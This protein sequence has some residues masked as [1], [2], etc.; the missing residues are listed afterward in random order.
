MSTLEFDVYPVQLVRVNFPKTHIELDRGATQAPPYRFPELS[1]E[2]NTKLTPDELEAFVLLEIKSEQYSNGDV[3]PGSFEEGESP[4]V[5]V[6]LTV[7]AAFQCIDEGLDEQFRKELLLRFVRGENPATVVWAY[8]RAHLA[9]VVSQTGLP[10]FHIP[11]VSAPIRRIDVSTRSPNEGD[12]KDFEIGT[13][14]NL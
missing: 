13:D 1:V 9:Y 4:A 10:T 6:D 14:E 11:L 2:I 8:V 3:Q 7:A 12:D 5:K